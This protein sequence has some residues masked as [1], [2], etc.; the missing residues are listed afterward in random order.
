MPACDDYTSAFDN[1]DKSN[2]RFFLI[3][4]WLGASDL[5]LGKTCSGSG[6]Y[7]A[8]AVVLPAATNDGN[9]LRRHRSRSQTRFRYELW[10]TVRL[11]R[12]LLRIGV[13]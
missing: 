4:N 8:V 7:P 9:A 3:R 13:G 11:F 10:L 2:C 1:W 5:R 6:T 12:A